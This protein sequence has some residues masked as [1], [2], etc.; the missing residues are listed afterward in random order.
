MVFFISWGV[1]LVFFIELASRLVFPFSTSP[2]DACHVVMGLTILRYG[3][4]LLG[5]LVGDLLPFLRCS[6]VAWRMWLPR[7][8]G[9]SNF[10]NLWFLCGSERGPWSGCFSGKLVAIAL[11][12]PM[13]NP[14]PVSSEASIRVAFWMVRKD[15]YVH[16]SFEGAC[17]RFPVC[18]LICGLF[19]PMHL[20]LNIMQESFA[21]KIN[22]S[23]V[24]GRNTIMGLVISV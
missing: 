19:G 22:R 7:F 12:L 23:W 18:P 3:R 8:K 2:L 6:F 24:Q 10:L 15:P 21:N 16:V 14:V 1:R 17:L 5:L 4:W 20:A 11:V 9:V 13:A